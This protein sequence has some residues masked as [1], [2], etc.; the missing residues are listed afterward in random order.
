M[1]AHNRLDMIFKNQF[2]TE[3]ENILLPISGHKALIKRDDT[4]H[5][6]ISGNKWRKL[7]GY[8]S[9]EQPI[10]T[11]GGIHSNHLLAYAGLAQYVDN[12]C[13]AIIRGRE[14]SDSLVLTRLVEGGVQCVFS[15]NATYKSLRGC[16]SPSFLFPELPH[17]IF[18]PEGGY[19]KHGLIGI[20][21]LSTELNA[22]LPYPA[23][24]VAACGTGTTIAGMAEFL[25]SRHSLTG[26]KMFI[27]GGIEANAASLTDKYE[28]IHFLHN[29]D[30]L[31]FAERHRAM[32][33]YIVDFYDLNKILLDPLYTGRMCYVVDKLISE[34]EFHPEGEPVFYH[35]GGLHGLIVYRKRYPASDLIFKA[36]SHLDI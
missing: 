30:V 25:D 28:R 36:L 2:P 31:K 14:N 21:E 27:D 22:Q 4:I 35:S 10:I 19:G 16:R 17:G 24:I 18:I 9:T 26:V 20:A 5:P 33:Q 32:E 34:N 12:L 23:H 29:K 7:K 8:L 3:I 13:Y 6:Y 11:C 15:D 1:S